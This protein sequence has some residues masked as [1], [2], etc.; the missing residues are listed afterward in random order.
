MT[1][2]NDYIEL[3]FSYILAEKRLSQNTFFAYKT[4]IEQLVSFLK[5]NHIAISQCGPEQLKLF[6]KFSFKSNFGL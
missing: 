1:L 2:R 4:D 6:L 5:N 3:F